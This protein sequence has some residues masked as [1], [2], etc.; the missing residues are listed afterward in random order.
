MMLNGGELDGVRILSPKTVHLMTIDHLGDIPKGKLTPGCGFG[1]GFAVTL[2]LSRTGIAGSVGE[3][4]WG[5]AAGTRF[6][7]DPAEKMIGIYMVQILP[8]TGLRYGD[9]FKVLAYQ[10]I[11]E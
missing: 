8:H 1:L 2:D 4:R 10:S 3:Y 7:I 9:T 6:W 5:G 11:V